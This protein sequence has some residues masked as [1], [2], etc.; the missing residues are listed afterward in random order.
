MGK[1]ATVTITLNYDSE[2][3]GILHG[4]VISDSEFELEIE[5]MVY[6][7]LRNYLMGEPIRNFATIEI[8]DV[9]QRPQ[10]TLER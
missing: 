9:K 6:D 10:Q 2:M 1:K 7:D 8:E 3:L 5:D 4:R